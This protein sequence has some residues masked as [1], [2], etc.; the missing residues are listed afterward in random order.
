L[1]A[2]PVLSVTT[3]SARA[4]TATV[5]LSYLASGFDWGA[6]YVATVAGDGRTLDLH[7]WMTLA[8]GSA[9]GFANAEVR[10]VAGRLNRRE[11]REL[12]GAVGALRLSCYPLGTT[13]SDL[14]RSEMGDREIVVTGSRTVAGEMSFFA[15]PPA[16]VSAPPPPENLGDLKLYR[17]PFRV[18]VAANAQ[19]QVALLAAAKVPFE[20]V[21][22]AAVGRGAQVADAPTRIAL[23][24]RN[25]VAGGLGIALPEGTTALY[26]ERGGGG[27]RLLLGT[28]TV[29]DAAVGE[30]MR[31]E[32]GT[33]SQVLVAQADGADGAA[34]LVVSNAN[35]VPATVEVTIGGAGDAPLRAPSMGVER[36]DGMW[37]WIVAVPANGRAELHY[38][39]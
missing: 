5:T 30:R 16:P 35:G 37:T 3:D 39:G 38:G 21:Y 8:N 12:E 34:T 13:T 31:I 28:G 15:A 17:V 32:A 19:K 6:S 9:E 2:R 18:N 33:S 36:I 1:S 25:E 10:A 14:R 24:V 23:R 26:A 7:A 11:M 20:R 27:G 29:R 4:G 22:R